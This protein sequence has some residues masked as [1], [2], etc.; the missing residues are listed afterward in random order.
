MWSRSLD[1]T[2][3]GEKFRVP[4]IH[5]LIALKLHSIKYNSHREL[6]DYPDI[7]HLVLANGID[8]ESSEIKSIVSKHAPSGALRKTVGIHQEMSTPSMEKPDLELNLPIVKQ[9]PLPKKVLSM[10][11]FDRFC[12]EDLEWA[13]DEEAYRAEK[14]RR[15]VTVPFRL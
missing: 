7:V 15:E 2:I 8:A 4:H 1:T 13:F 11:E 5:H 12:R 14:K 6:L 9:D 10:D 3:A